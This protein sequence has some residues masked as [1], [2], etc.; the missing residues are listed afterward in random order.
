MPLFDLPPLRSARSKTLQGSSSPAV[1]SPRRNLRCHSQPMTDPWNLARTDAALVDLGLPSSTVRNSSPTSP[2]PQLLA[3]NWSPDAAARGSLALHMLSQVRSQGARPPSSRSFGNAPSLEGEAA[4]NAAREAAREAAG[5]ASAERAIVEALQ[6]DDPVEAACKLVRRLI[7]G[8]SSSGGA[9]ETRQLQFVL[10][11]LEKVQAPV[12]IAPKEDMRLKQLEP[13]ELEMDAQTREYLAGFEVVR[14][15]KQRTL[16]Q[17]VKAVLF[18]HRLSRLLSAC[19]A[20][21][22]SG[23]RQ[24]SQGSMFFLDDDVSE[25]LVTALSQV[26]S[27]QSFDVFHV[28]ELS[29]QRP[30]LHV[31]ITIMSHR[32]L[33]RV[34]HVK[35][36]KFV[37]FI[38]EIEALYLDNPYH[39]K[40]HAAEVVQTT[41]AFLYQSSC[42]W[43]ELEVMS[44]LLAGMCHDVGHPGFTNGYRVMIGDDDALTY[45]DKSVNENM[46]SAITQRVLQNE[47]CNFLSPVSREQFTAIRKLM[48][49]IILATDMVHHTKKLNKYRTAVEESGRDPSKWDSPS[50][51]LEWMTHVADISSV[52]KPMTIAEL[53]TD[54]LLREFFQQGDR[55]REQGLPVSPMCDRNT[56]SR[57]GSQVGFVN[58]IV[59]PSLQALGE[60]CNVSESMNNLEA[61]NDVYTKRQAAE[62]EE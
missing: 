34:F 44:V 15:K 4:R 1:D 26:A 53:W 54:R 40:L 31:G 56:V 2:L 39:N 33:L 9:S 46:H 23:A 10:Q 41:H 20:S 37:S 62:K 18:T 55:E 51:A 38:S 16:R 45:N 19:C 59:R 48:I 36:A 14:L 13:A 29:A 30:L 28:S 32:G 42:V 47:G 61:Y 22:R 50:L 3:V 52:T 25:D 35:S 57:A 24:M 7:L 11:V 49:D 21:P 43:S 12:R 5:E 58:F 6:A 8:H 60:T 17:V 27:I